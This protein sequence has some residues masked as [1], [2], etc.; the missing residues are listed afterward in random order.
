MT[1]REE[2][3][4]LAD[5]AGCRVGEMLVLAYAN[6]PFNAGTD[7]DQREAAWFADVW[8]QLGYTGGVHLRRIHYRVLSAGL[9]LA[10]GTAY[11][12][13]ERCWKHL[14]IAAKKARELGFV[15]PDLFIDRR[16][17]APAIFAGRPRDTAAIPEWEFPDDE[18][19]LLV[20]PSV[21][22][23]LKSFLKVHSPAAIGYDYEPDDQAV[24]LEVWIEKSTMNDVL[25]PVCARHHANLVT[26]VGFQSITNAVMLLQRA[27]AANK[28]TRVF[29]VSDF[30]PAGT[31]MP[32][33]AARQVEYWCERYAPGC[34]VKLT[35]LALS[36][37][38]VAEYQLPAHRSRTATAG[39]GTSR[40]ATAPAP[41]S[42]TPSRRSTP[43]RSP[44]CSN[45]R[46]P[47]TVTR[48]S[49]PIFGQPSR[50]PMS[51][52]ARNG[53]LSPQTCAPTSTTS[54]A[55]PT[56]SPPATATT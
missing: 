10:D 50:T 5:E 23:R 40:T 16:N 54:A 29:Y 28:P 26:S 47:R 27:A 32:I 6:D 49:R 42:S 3:R 44:E 34:D 35:P 46:S 8:D 7:I 53:E 19:S 36:V 56:P 13:T 31:M 38:Q 55:K 15:N 43:E 45:Q 1:S 24:H 21:D 25:A 20:L 11:V 12:N 39:P 2:I 14:Q 41:S 9:T 33:A 51:S 52:C 37:E 22:V 4:K 30:D 48:T 17:A 18:A